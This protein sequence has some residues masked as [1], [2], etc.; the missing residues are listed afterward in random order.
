MAKSKRPGPKRGKRGS[1]K[2]MTP[3]TK[4]NRSKRAVDVS[5]PSSAILTPSTESVGKFLTKT[6]SPTAKKAKLKN[7]AERRKKVRKGILK[8]IESSVK[9][10]GLALKYAAPAVAAGYGA[11]RLGASISGGNPYVSG[12][13]ALSGAVGRLI[14]ESI[15]SAKKQGLPTPSGMLVR[16]MLPAILDDQLNPQESKLLYE[17]EWDPA[18]RSS[19]ADAV[20]RADRGMLWGHEQKDEMDLTQ[21]FL[22]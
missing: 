11:Y 18:P 12:S 6:R 21:S 5:L 16:E 14:D 4:V 19:L 20:F 2:A 22:V 10:A 17:G 9:R 13:M 3:S 8:G 7:R 1:K 15:K